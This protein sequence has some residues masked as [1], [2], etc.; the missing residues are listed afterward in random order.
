MKKLN[1][2]VCVMTGILILI[3]AINVFTQDWPQWRG[4]NRDEKVTGFTA[5]EKWPDALIQKWQVTVGLGDASPVLV[6]KKLYVFA[7][8]DS[9]EVIMCLNASSGKELW[10]NKYPALAATGPAGSHPGPRSTPTVANG[11]VVTLGVGGVLSCF[12]ANNGKL[13]WRN[14]EYTKEL[15]QFYTAIS[16]IVLDGKCIAHLGGKENGVI[17]AFDLNTGTPKWQWAGDAPTYSSPI[18]MTVAGTKQVIVH[19]GKNLLGLALKDGKQLWQIPTPPQRR[20][21]NSATAIIDGQTV[22]YTSQGEGTKAA[23]IKKEGENFV[24]NPLWHNEELGTSFN[25][26]VLK[27]GFLY[28]LS[29]KG[30]LF[31]IN[32]AN[33]QTAWADTTRYKNFGSTVDGGS[34]ILTVTSDSKLI[35]YKATEKEFAELARIKVAETPIYAHPLFADKRIYIKDE[36][37]LTLWSVE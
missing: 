5:P 10:Q 14:E 6:G 31:C 12:D 18:Q 29:D 8:Q 15:P 30:K 26:P 1:R 32:V 27:T 28:G 9:N 35:V 4:V 2:F 22:I 19:T 23:T 11:K 17:I 36:K 7:R 16:P 34:V 33:G 37:N 3:L 24:V 20:F 13:L 21:Y 25:T